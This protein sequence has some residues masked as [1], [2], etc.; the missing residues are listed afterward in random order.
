MTV[1]Q[2]QAICKEY[3]RLDTEFRAAKKD[4][5]VPYSKVTAL[6]VQR[7]ALERQTDLAIKF[8]HNQKIA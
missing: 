3:D 1:E 5:R 8:L 7:D 2:A 6:K 4:K